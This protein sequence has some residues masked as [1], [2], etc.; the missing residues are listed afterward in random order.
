MSVMGNFLIAVGLFGSSFVTDINLFYF[1][2]SVIIGMYKEISLFRV[3]FRS[4]LYN[5]IGDSRVSQDFHFASVALQSSIMSQPFDIHDFFTF[6]KQVS[7]TECYQHDCTFLN[8]DD[9]K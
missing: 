5:P 6:L 4:H 2:Y 3:L 9:P 7:V 1:T 8:R